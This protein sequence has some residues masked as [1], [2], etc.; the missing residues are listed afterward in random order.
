MNQIEPFPLAYHRGERHV[1][2]ASKRK[3]TM[4]STPIRPKEKIKDKG[5]GKRKDKGKELSSSPSDGK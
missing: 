5:K 4:T 1:F 2:V 3:G